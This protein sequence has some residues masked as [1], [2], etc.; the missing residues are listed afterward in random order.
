MILVLHIQP[1]SAHSIHPSIPSSIHQICV[2]L[3]YLPLCC[4]AASPINI[5]HLQYLVRGQGQLYLCG[6]WHWLWE[7]KLLGHWLW[8]CKL[9]G[10]WLWEG[11]V[12]GCGVWSVVGRGYLYDRGGWGGGR[13][14]GFPYLVVGTCIRVSGRD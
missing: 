4:G 14:L 12:L 9:L 13:H 1:S 10:H 11:M 8:E 5:N 3:C 6:H 7:C 2:H